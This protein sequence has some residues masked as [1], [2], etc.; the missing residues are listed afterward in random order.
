MVIEHPSTRRIRFAAL[1]IV[2]ILGLGAWFSFAPSARKLCCSS[3]YK[4]F[5]SPDQQFQLT[6]YRIGSPWPM[7]PGGAGDAPGY[8]RLHARN[9]AVLQEQDIEM[10]QLVDQVQWQPHRV[11]I[12]LVADWAL[13]S[14]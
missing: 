7:S 10:V 12:K 5:V 6:V 9:G 14:P 2:G 8:I 13:P 4:T 1:L 3:V 11:E